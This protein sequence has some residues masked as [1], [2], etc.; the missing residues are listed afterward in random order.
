MKKKLAFMLMALKAGRNAN[1]SLL[2][3]LT[4]LVPNRDLGVFLVSC[5]NFLGSGCDCSSG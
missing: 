2:L 5:V 3:G 4:L 1:S